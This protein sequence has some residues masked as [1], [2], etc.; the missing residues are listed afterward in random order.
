MNLLDSGLFGG[1]P[2]AKPVGGY[3]LD[4]GMSDTTGGD[5]L[6]GFSKPKVDLKETSNID[7]EKFQNFWM[8]LPEAG[9]IDA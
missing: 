6:G 9:K 1:A 7:G 5:L 8:Q 3:S 2:Q 4:L